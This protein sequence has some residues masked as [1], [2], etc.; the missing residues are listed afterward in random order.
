MLLFPF[1]YFKN[2]YFNNGYGDFTRIKGAM[3][4]Q[5]SLLPW[6][7]SFIIRQL[8]LVSGQL[9]FFAVVNSVL[10][11][12]KAKFDSGKTL[13]NMVLEQIES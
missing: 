4:F 13:K 3:K 6:G 8:Y 7:T 5:R 2:I 1:Y 9:A 10:K 11:H 12:K